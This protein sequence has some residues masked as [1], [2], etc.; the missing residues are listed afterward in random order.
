MLEVY[1]A[2]METYLQGLMSAMAA[3]PTGLAAVETMLRFHFTFTEAHAQRFLVVLRDFPFFFAQSDPVN[4]KKVSERIQRT[5]SLLREALD[6][7]QDGLSH[8]WR[9]R[10]GN[11]DGGNSI[12]GSS[13]SCA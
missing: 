10:R 12:S 1:H 3:A 4:R 2:I 13:A 5:V 11:P 9:R 8:G 6:K 7:G